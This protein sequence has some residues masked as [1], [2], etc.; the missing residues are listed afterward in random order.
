MKSTKGKKGSSEGKMKIRNNEMIKSK[1]ETVEIRNCYSALE[2]D[3]ETQL[4]ENEKNIS[5]YL[6]RTATSMSKT[7]TKLNKQEYTNTVSYQ[8]EPRERE[9]IQHN[10]QS[11]GIMPQQHAT[12]GMNG[13]YKIPTI[14]NRWE[15]WEIPAMALDQRFTLPQERKLNTNKRD[16]T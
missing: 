16:A 12:K 1:I 7:N 2:T 4:Y 14:I 11:K 6:S 13:T 5:E 3:D 10:L 15:P 8:K 9:G